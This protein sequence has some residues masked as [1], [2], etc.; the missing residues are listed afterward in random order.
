[1]SQLS[2]RDDVHQLRESLGQKSPSTVVIVSRGTCGRSR[3]ADELVH[4]L[5]SEIARTETNGSIR[6][7]VTGCLGYCDQEPL[8]IIRPQGFFYPRPEIEDVPEIV[9]KSVLR[10]TRS[11]VGVVELA[12]YA[13]LAGG[14]LVR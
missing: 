14:G 7:R 11:A 13:C 4:A 3:G 12:I 6:L 5:E 10:R 8:V 9:A 1:M 2:T